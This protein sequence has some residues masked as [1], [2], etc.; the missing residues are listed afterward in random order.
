[1][2][3]GVRLQS[4]HVTSPSVPLSSRRSRQFLGTQLNKLDLLCR[5]WRLSELEIQ[6]VHWESSD[7]KI[8][9]VILLNITQWASYCVATATTSLCPVRIK[10]FPGRTQSFCATS[11]LQM[12]GIIGGKTQML[13]HS[14]SKELLVNNRKYKFSKFIAIVG[15]SMRY[16]I[17]IKIIMELTAAYI[18]QP[19]LVTGNKIILAKI[20]NFTIENNNQ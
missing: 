12:E 15:I 18:T 4:C 10:K 8:R 16:Y 2:T 19:A 9:N 20:C 14:R 5:Y 11:W 17:I 13:Q 3:R 1:M 6:L 7:L